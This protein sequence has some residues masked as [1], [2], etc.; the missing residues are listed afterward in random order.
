MPV[1]LL[2][3]L[4]EDVIWRGASAGLRQLRQLAAV[5]RVAAWL[6]ALPGW[7]ALVLFLI[8]EA[9][10]RLGELWALVLMAQHHLS[11]AI[12][13]YVLVRLLAALLAVFVFQS[14]EPALMRIAWFATLMRWIRAARDWAMALI[15]PTRDRLLAVIRS[16]PRLLGRRIAA[17]RRRLRTRRWRNPTE[18]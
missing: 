13:V 16:G 4:A 3:I 9:V 2:L 15:R 8:P 1:A 5:R 18:P 6:G 12:A 14:C 17:Q 11:S 10:G 7:L